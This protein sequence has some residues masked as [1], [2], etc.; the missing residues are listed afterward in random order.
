M[1]NPSDVNSQDYLYYDKNKPPQ[2]AIM[3]LSGVV[4]FVVGFALAFFILWYES[5]L[6]TK[7]RV[8]EENKLKK[9][10]KAE[11]ERRIRDFIGK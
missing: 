10:D 1:D 9:T 4:C 2:E 3:A 5:T 7:T 6:Q 11:Y 8:V